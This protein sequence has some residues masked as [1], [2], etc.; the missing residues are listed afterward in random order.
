MNYG[1]EK[2]SWKSIFEPN[3]SSLVT[4]SKGDTLDNEALRAIKLFL[5]KKK[6]HYNKIKSK[7]GN[8]KYKSEQCG[9]IPILVA[10]WVYSSGLEL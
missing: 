1:K 10:F 7:L 9:E 8:L 4:V 5:K 3:S 6:K 2:T